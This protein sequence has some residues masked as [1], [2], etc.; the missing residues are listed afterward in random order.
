MS[1]LI[2][3]SLIV[4]IEIYKVKVGEVFDDAIGNED[5]FFAIQ[6]SIEN[7]GAPAPVGSFYAS[8]PADF[9]KYGGAVLRV[10]SQMPL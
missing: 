6:V 5:V 10:N 7:Q 2:Y 1:V 4:G 8:P 3:F 9:S